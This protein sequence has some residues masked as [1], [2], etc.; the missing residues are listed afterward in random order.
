MPVDLHERESLTR[1]QQ[2]RRRRQLRRR[3]R[4]RLYLRLFT[5]LIL[6][7]AVVAGAVFGIR[8]LQSKN[9]AAR[10][11]G[12]QEKIAGLD[13]V[14]TDLLPVN[15]YSRPGRT[16]PEVNAIV[17]HYVG[18]PKTTAA[19][20][21]RYYEGLAESGDTYAS[22]NFLVGLDG[23][24][25]ECVPVNEVAY[26]SNWRNDDTLSIE[27]CHPDE[28]GQFNARTYDALVKLTAWLCNEYG[29]S[30]SDVIRH[31][32]VTGK[33]CPKYYV[34]HPEAWEAFK[35]DVQ[36]ELDALSAAR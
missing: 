29:L 34:E 18:N 10:Y 14:S 5:V 33:L 31:Y 27:C 22:S 24:I 11:A 3:R 36:V 26:C 16:L 35:T 25:L 15:T 32:D 1:T 20:N 7:A 6:A 19:Q 8:A 17:V 2:H 21:R 23:E 12:I 30:S 4:L 28:T 9:E 13:W